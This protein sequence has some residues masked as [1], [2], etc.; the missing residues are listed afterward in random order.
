MVMVL[1][2]NIGTKVLNDCTVAKA[3]STTHVDMA[4]VSYL[5]KGPSPVDMLRTC[6]TYIGQD[7]AP[8]LPSFLLNNLVDTILT[9]EVG[10]LT[11]A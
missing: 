9:Q 5:P 11:W 4:P 7:R 10:D 2:S 1:H 6:L 8:A 3:Q